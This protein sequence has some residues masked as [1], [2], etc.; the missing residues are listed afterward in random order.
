M[1]SKKIA[2]HALAGTPAFGHH[3][4]P[5]CR[6][7]DTPTPADELFYDYANSP[8]PTTGLYICTITDSLRGDGGFRIE[9]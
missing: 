1:V 8:S 9:P 4:A 7:T 3:S 6:E 2:G 5:R